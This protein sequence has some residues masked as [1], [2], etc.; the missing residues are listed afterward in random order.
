MS[1]VTESCVSAIGATTEIQKNGGTCVILFQRPFTSWNTMNYNN[2]WRRGR[3]P[4]LANIVDQS[5]RDETFEAR[6]CANKSQELTG[7]CAWRQWNRR[8]ETDIH[9][10]IAVFGY[11][12]LAMRCLEKCLKKAAYRIKIAVGYHNVS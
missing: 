8:Y 9:L 2:R 5:E 6:G 7:G 12:E 1:S 11:T 10:Y 4:R 3:I